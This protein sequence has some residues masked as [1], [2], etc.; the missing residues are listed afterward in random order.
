MTDE[1]ERQ[2]VSVRGHSGGTG[3]VKDFILIL[4]PSSIRS[5]LAA[6]PPFFSS[7]VPSA[8][9]LTLA[10]ARPPF[11]AFTNIP[12]FNSRRP[13]PKLMSRLTLNVDGSK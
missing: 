1:E 2:T 4:P 5:Q 6:S 3:R 10:L 13:F 9:I 7:F 12:V 11:D 8:F